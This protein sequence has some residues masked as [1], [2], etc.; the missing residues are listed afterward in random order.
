MRRAGTAAAIREILGLFDM[1]QEVGAALDEEL[2]KRAAAAASNPAAGSAPH[3][4]QPSSL[5]GLLAGQHEEGQPRVNLDE[6]RQ[7]AAAAI[8][9]R[10][11]VLAQF[12]VATKLIEDGRRLLAEAKAEGVTPPLAL[13]L[14]VVLGR[15]D[16]ILSL[17]LAIETSAL[18]PGAAREVTPRR[19]ALAKLGQ[20]LAKAAATLVVSPD[21]STA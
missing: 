17:L 11:L 5:L 8:L 18:P 12:Q 4:R 9:L 20:A 14:G 15:V 13:R 21:Q 3:G 2:S 6:Q 16:T 7:R 19:E 1:V 10:P